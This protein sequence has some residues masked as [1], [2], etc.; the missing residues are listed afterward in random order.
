MYTLFSDSSINKLFYK[1]LDASID[2][3]K[4]VVRRGG[5]TTI[6]SPG[7]VCVHLT[8]PRN[9]VLTIPG[10]ASCFPAACAEA[11]WVIAGRNDL[12]FLEFFLPRAVDFSDDGKTWR[13]GYG[14]RIRTFPDPYGGV[15]QLAFVVDELSGDR[16][17]RRAVMTLLDPSQ[18][19]R[20][21][22]KTKDF[23][24]TQSLSFMVRNDKLDLTV[25]IRSND[26]IWGW[27][28]I[29]C[30]EFCTLQEIV[31]LIT[32]IPLGEFY[33]VSNSLHIYEDMAGRVERISSRERFDVYDHYQATAYEYCD[34]LMFLDH[35]LASAFR[36]LSGEATT[37]EE[38]LWMENDL[39]A[40]L[41]LASLSF[42]E[43]NALES[44]ES[45][46]DVPFK[47][48]VLEWLSRTRKLAPEA[49]AY[50]KANFSDDVCK[51]IVSN[52]RAHD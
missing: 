31:S 10:R 11:L 16:T 32:T 21:P 5:K 28:H 43:K 48:G 30:F 44:V 13:A 25:F 39:I 20:F 9:K 29:N 3:P 38:W 12:E 51:Y 41:T 8:N 19:S 27:S 50:V 24:C 42:K 15:D 23:P 33:V 35:S 26:F 22:I 40:D 37:L 47:I 7:P 4:A 18:D 17:S 36:R 45:M 2:W 52:G 46:R 6:D 1:I 34:A 14:P 49:L